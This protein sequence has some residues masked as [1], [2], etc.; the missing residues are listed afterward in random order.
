MNEYLSARTERHAYADMFP[1]LNAAIAF[2]EAE[3]A[4]ETPFRDLLARQ[5]ATA[6]NTTIDEA[7]TVVD[8]LV[9]WWK[10]G[11]RWHRPLNGDPD[12]ETK[13]ARMILA[14]HN[15]RRRAADTGDATAALSDQ[16]RAKHPGALFIA[17]KKDSTWVVATASTR[18][19]ANHTDK[20][21]N[22]Y[23]I[24]VGPLDVFVDVVE[25]T[26]TGRSRQTRTWQ[27]LEPSVVSRWTMLHSTDRWEK[28]NRRARRAEH[29]S[30][31][32]IEAAV[33][34]FQGRPAPSGHQLIAV[35][36]DEVKSWH[37]DRPKF[38]LWY[39]P[40]HAPKVPARRLTER[41]GRLECLTQEVTWQRE[42]GGAVTLM[43]ERTPSAINSTGWETA[44]NTFLDG[45]RQGTVVEPWARDNRSLLIV[46]FDEQVHAAAVREAQTWETNRVAIA[47]LAA[48]ADRLVSSIERAWLERATAQAKARFMEDYADES[49][50]DDHA[51]SLK[52]TVP[53]GARSSTEP[54]EYRGTQAALDWLVRRLTED[55][56]APYGLTVREAIADLGEDLVTLPGTE[57]AYDSGGKVV[58]VAEDVL[59]LRFTVGP[60]SQ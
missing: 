45:V 58:G 6:D 59:D 25:Y 29:L 17:R 16:L 22:R 42:Q 55:G 4:E 32:E 10:I 20:E 28:W 56:L 14:E 5:I 36:Y 7:T 2:K 43:Y 15:A 51:K 3:K 9:A 48:E 49:L 35:M 13:A 40:N 41:M 52:I 19:W 12:A 57:W 60:A 24:Q 34:E 26:K 37:R 31:P 46:F 1:T 53:F 39:Q 47:R 50:W 33:A 44:H 27:V 21:S 54:K 30:D 11:N 38:T 23:G 8:D 18:R